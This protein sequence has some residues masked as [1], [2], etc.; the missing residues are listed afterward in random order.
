MNSRAVRLALL[1]SLFLASCGSSDRRLAPAKSSSAPAAVARALTASVAHRD[2][3]VGL[4]T[5]VWIHANDEAPFASAM[6]A[7]TASLHAVAPAFELSRDAVSAVRVPVIHDTGAGPIVARFEQR[8]GDVEVFRGGLNVAL[9]RK[10]EPVAAS[11]LIAP[12][13]DGSTRPFAISARDALAHAF[14]E[15]TGATPALAAIDTVAGY[16]RF[17]SAGLA[18]PARVKKVF[19][20]AGREVVPGYY[21]E[22]MLA[23]GGA[24]SYVISA[25]TGAVLFSNDLVRNDTFTYRAF[26][27]PTTLLPSDGPQGNAAAPHPAGT[28][29]GFKPALGT[30]PLVTLQN[31]P[32]S[33]NDPWLPPGA[34]VTTGNNVDAYADVAQGDGFGAG[35]VRPVATSAGTFDYLYD[36]LQ[37]PAANATQRNASATQMFYLMNFLHDWFYDAGFDEKSGNHQKDNFGRGGLGNDPLL[38]E[39]QDYSGRNNANAATPADGASARIQMFVFSGPSNASITVDTP[40]SIAGDKSVGTGGFGKDAFDL[41]GSVVLAD[42]ATGTDPADACEP[43]QNDVRGKIVL[44]HRGICSFV[45]KAQNAQNAGAVGAIIANVA[46]SA[47]PT[48]PPFMGG[49]SSTV[50]IPVLSLALADGQAIEGALSSGVTL[51]MKRSLQ[52]DLDGALDTSVASHEWGHTISNRLIANGAGL[53]TNQSG[54]LGEGWGDFTAMLV[55]VREDDALSPAGANWEGAYPEGGYAMLGAGAD[56]YFGIRRVPYSIDLQKDPLT[57][58]H[59]SN[60]VPLPSNVP[61]SFGEDGSFNSE[62]HNTGEIWATMLWECYA[63]L[64][65]DPRHTFAQAQEKMKR[66]YVASL[67]LTPVEPTLLEARDAVLA[68]A[69]AGDAQDYALF[70]Q[71]FAKRGAG[72]GAEGP[73]KD[74]TTNAGVVESYLVGNQVKVVK[75]AFDDDVVTC[76]HDGFLDDLELGTISLTLKNVGTGTLTNTTARLSSSVPQVFF[77]DGPTLAVPPLRPFETTVLEAHVS[78]MPGG[79]FGPIELHVTL[80]DASF[81][82]SKSIDVKVPTRYMTDETP[83]SSSIDTVEGRVTDWTVSAADVSGATRKWSRT[84]DGTNHWWTVPNGAEVSQHAL[85]SPPFSPAG[86]SFGIN[87]KHRWSFRFSTRRNVPLDGGVIELST[88]DGKTW[89]DVSKFGQVDYGAP[90]DDTSSRADNPLKGRPAYT[91]KSDGYPDKWI[92]SHIQVTLPEQPESVRIRFLEA[93][94]T[95][96]SGTGAPGWDVDDIEITGA[97]TPFTGFAPHSDQCDPNG[98]TADA[99]PGKTVRPLDAVKLEGT[100]SHPNGAPLTFKW[101]QIAGP[102]VQLQGADSATIAFTAPDAAVPT[103]LTFVLHT[104]DGKLLSPASRVD[105]SVAPPAPLSPDL[106]EISGGCACRASPSDAGSPGAWAGLTLGALALLR[107]RR[108]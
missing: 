82:Q 22:I 41:T 68:A 10:L 2:P 97:G 80:D 29:N 67:K 13:L 58:K 65:R 33:K 54:G 11:G 12:T 51:E 90:I 92:P 20:P 48:V 83:Q 106:L 39:A 38:A 32:F 63:A 52:V 70:W 47:Q 35:D 9:T 56:Y 101:A 24:R 61:V 93:S 59:I 98:P 36:P 72:V 26:A 87:F 19:F 66:Y 94:G 81:I 105:V 31:F 95:S 103:V 89:K 44:I 108:R 46:S 62:V 73:P 57:F 107:R 27:S 79:P 99:G 28:P 42:D 8:F 49:T 14:V 102:P 91:N 53:T 69:L 78:V 55:T 100:G 21:A 104:S 34:T 86:T 45:Q 23:R 37:P 40:A 6:E 43:L 7:A 85:V 77:P 50:T 64:L 74:S 18:Q 30:A 15:M 71:A 1:G 75:A 5:F 88:D 96:F 60:G 25:E 76:D 4:P 17:A 16:D 84:G 3:K